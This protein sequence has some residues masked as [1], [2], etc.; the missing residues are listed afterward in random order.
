M[1]YLKKVYFV[2]YFPLFHFSLY[3]PESTEGCA[4]STVLMKLLT[5]I[6]SHVLISLR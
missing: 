6:I 5:V 4:S 1:N 2:Y 3:V